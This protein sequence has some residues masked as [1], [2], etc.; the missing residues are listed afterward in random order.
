MFGFATKILLI[1]TLVGFASFDQKQVYLSLDL[2]HE[3]SAMAWKRIE[4]LDIPGEPRMN[5]R[6]FLL[7]IFEP[8]ANPLRDSALKVEIKLPKEKRF[9]DLI[10]YAW[11]FDNREIQITESL[12]GIRIQVTRNVK[13]DLDEDFA[14][15][16]KSIIRVKGTD[17][18]GE[19]YELSIPRLKDHK[20]GDSFSSNP[21]ARIP[22]MA[23]WRDRFDGVVSDKYFEI[24]FYKRIEQ[25]MGFRK[26]HGWIS[27]QIGP[28]A[29]QTGR[30]RAGFVEQ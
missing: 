12:N 22:T 26:G 5:S 25:L 21:E 2:I 29:N 17:I 11:R 6:S 24:N 3:D 28:N 19:A 10:R 13:C 7:Q 8:E 27:N 9:N 16:M 1:A 4:Y 23:S 15:I 30:G 14:K 20:S 18:Y